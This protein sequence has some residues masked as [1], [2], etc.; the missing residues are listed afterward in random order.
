MSL[1]LNSEA[2]QPDSP[3]APPAGSP[4]R[5]H[6]IAGVITGQVAGLAMA[7]AVMFGFGALLG[8]TPILPFQAI[9]SLF[10]GQSALRPEPHVGAF[11][12]GLL[13]HQLGPSLIWGLLMG[14]GSFAMGAVRG[15]AIVVL[16]TSIGIVAQLVDV[17]MLLLVAYD[18]LGLRDIWLQHAPSFWS[19]VAHFVFGLTLAAVFPFAWGR[20]SAR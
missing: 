19:W 7:A 6:L 8:T 15:S 9:G 1:N 5:T 10:F 3:D 2:S 11:V 20:V 18:V 14:F 12:A 4:M 17:N 16:G 13:L